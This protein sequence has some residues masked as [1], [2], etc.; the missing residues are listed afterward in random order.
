MLRTALISLALLLLLPAQIQAAPSAD[1]RRKA[2]AQIA[3]GQHMFKKGAYSRALEAF[4]ASSKLAP[5]HGVDLLIAATL[6]SMGRSTE[7]AAA[8]NAYLERH[9]KTAPR[10]ARRE[11]W[12]RLDGLKRWLGR[13]QI[14][15]T[16]AGARVTVD[17]SPHGTLPLAGPLYLNPGPHLVSIVRDGQTLYEATVQLRRGDFQLL[18]V[19]PQP[20]PA[21]EPTTATGTA[22]PTPAGTPKKLVPCAPLVHEPP[23]PFCPVCPTDE[24]ARARRNMTIGGYVALG[25]G[26][27]LASGAAVLYGVG[28]ARGS[29]AHDRYM[30]TDNPNAMA[31]HYADVEQARTM[32]MVGHGLAAAGVVAL[33]LSLYQ[34]IARPAAPDQGSRAR[35]SAGL[36]P[37]GGSVSLGGSF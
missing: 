33:G 37:G 20:K 7:A 22:G 5:G 18:T 1:D 24:Q 35:L 10:A 30:G 6:E 19:D 2:R 17:D 8:Y 3:R 12:L 9:G 21:P 34:F 23:E 4:R 14:K 32:V 25:A 28:G 15:S 11:A 29:R 13:L 27:V 26:L 36:V 16:A 31:T